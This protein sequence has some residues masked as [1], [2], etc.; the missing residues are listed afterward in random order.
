V[1]FCTLW[2]RR[3]GRIQGCA[4]RWLKNLKLIFNIFFQKFG[5]KLQWRLWR[6]SN[7]SLN[8]HNSGH[9]MACAIATTCCISDVP[10]QWESQKF[11]PH[12]SHIFQPVF[13]KLTTK[14][15]IRDTTLHAKFGWCGMTGRGSAKMAN[16]GNYFWF[17]HFCTLR[18]ASRSH[19]RTD[20]D[21]WGLKMRVSAQGSAFW[22]SRW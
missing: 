21:Q 15:D 5:K 19:R 11:D 2:L 3:R 8:D 9:V 22:G 20:H 14:N 4:F 16:F 6:K 13:L 18:V 17:F 10:S 12:C 7:N 1:E